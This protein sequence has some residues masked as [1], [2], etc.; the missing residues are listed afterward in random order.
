MRWLIVLLIGSL[1]ASDL[2]G[3]SM[4]LGPGLSVKNAILYFLAL[5]LV[6]RL[7]LS[8]QRGLE[9][10]AVMVAFA[11]L[12][13]YAVFSWL[14]AS[15]VIRYPR[16]D[17]VA[18]GISLKATLLDAALFFF[19]AFYA[20]RTRA[21][22]RLVLKAFVIALTVANVFTL[23]DVIGLTNLGIRIGAR[24]AEAG[25]VFGAFGH[26]NETAGLIVVMLPAVAAFAATS[27]GAVRAAWWAAAL[28][29]LTVLIMTVSRGAFVAAGL[30]TLW[31]LYVCR[32]V[33]PVGV[34]V[35]GG[36]L[37]LGSV[38]VVVFFVSLLNPEIGDTIRERIVGQSTALDID[39]ASSGRVAI[40]SAALSR[41]MSAPLTLV[42][43]FGWDAYGSM[44][45]HYAT[46]NHY[47][48]VWFELGLPGL[49]AFVFLLAYL[50]VTARR[51][52]N[53]PHDELHP[54]LVAYIFG[55][56]PLAIAIFFGNHANTWPYV[57]LLSGIAMRAAVLTLE[58]ARR[59]A[60]TPV[61]AHPGHR[62]RPVAMQRL[63]NFRPQQ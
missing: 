40:W 48:L 37:V 42:T 39:E 15:F 14:A 19:A 51:A 32:R 9:M 5:A 18:S 1:V 21:D 60:P 57:W 16:Y 26:A 45:F 11:A 8:D 55:M 23:T 61:P 46:H 49:A 63:G 30:G 20:V 35:R 4:S 29:S 31:A 27:R 22:V 50:I 28:V 25:R 3:L 59:G 41:M 58:H 43:G 33:M 62:A 10:P 6:A 53:G 17:L 56:L 34:L 38:A 7:I 52:L 44:P 2:L 24:G 36:A 47:L 13:G 54:Y 12:I